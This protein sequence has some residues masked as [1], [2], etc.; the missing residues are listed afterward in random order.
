MAESE[1][2]DVFVPAGFER[3][4]EGD[5]LL[6]V[7]RELADPVQRALSP[8]HQAWSRIAQRRFTARGRAGVATFQLGKDQPAMMVRRYFHGGLFASVGRDLYFGPDRAINELISAETAHAAGVRTPTAIGILGRRAAGPFWRLAFLSSEIADSEDLV[9]YACRLGEYPAETAAMEKRGVL[10]EAAQQIR[11]MHDAGV[12]HADLH[13]KNLLL[14]RRVSGPPEVYVID[15]DGST[16]GAPLDVA[17]REKNLKRLARSVRKIRVA[18]AV[19]TAWD[20][21]RFLRE[22]LHDRPE[23]RQLMR[24]WARR[25][26]DSG[27]SHEIWWTMTAAQ[28]TL[29]GDKV[30]R[31]GGL[32][33]TAR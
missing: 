30:G 13:L 20:R 33:R 5:T 21:L 17:Q 24:L 4:Q 23:K 27:K 32:R 7:R 3:R 8:L 18:D 28:R 25:L 9:H 14:K 26:A 1:T 2:T 10:R 11:K 16:V 15:F 12:F 31:I 19:L 6:I 29:K 22:Y